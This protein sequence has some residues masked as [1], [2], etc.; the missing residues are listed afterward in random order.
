MRQS[1]LLLV[2]MII[3]GLTSLRGPAHVVAADENRE[4]E[5]VSK[6][7]PEN[8]DAWRNLK[9]GMFIHWGPVS[10]K[11]TEIGW[12]RGGE[13]RGLGFKGLSGTHQVPVEVYDNLYKQFN[14]T[15]FDAD[16]WVQ[17]AK[18]AGMKYI[19]FTT[20][21]HDGFCNFDTKLTDYKIT[22]PESPYGRDIVRQLADACHHGDLIWGVYYSQPDWHHPDY[23][24]GKERHKRYIEYLHGQMR[25]LLTQYGKTNMIFFDGL[26]GKSE[27]WDAPR[28]INMCRELQ[29]GIMINNRAGVKADFDT[30][31]QRIGKMQTDRP[32][33]TCM[34]ICRQ[35]AWKPNDT[36]KSFQQ[37]IQ[38]LVRVVGGDGN[39]L[40]NVGPMPDGR[41]E[42]R[43]VERLK[44]MGAWLAKYGQSIYDTRGG[45]FAAGMWGASTYRD[46]VIYLHILNGGKTPITLP[47]IEKKILA[48]D[49]LTGGRAAVAQTGESITVTLS[50]DAQNEVD[51]IVVLKLDGP[52]AEAN[53]GTLPSETVSAWK[54]ATASNVFRRRVDSYG[55]QMA[56]DDDPATRWATD[57]DTKKAWLEVDLGKPTTIDRAMI[58]EDKSSRVRRFELTVQ[59]DDEPWKTLVQGRR[60]GDKLDLEFAPV[61]AR[62]VRFNILEATDGPT[63]SEFRLF[64]SKK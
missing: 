34:T 63:I 64:A 36:M 25:E 38:T 33:E 55:P 16:Q 10:L 13:R 1:T 8:V 9:F 12:S 28:L 35:W 52:A 57:S 24:N 44:E 4:T 54:K 42:P 5:A 17:I 14:P 2:V 45:P 22:S 3:L 39:L 46:N 40:F 31:E 32:W 56:V 20:K 53:P 58:I 43:Q 11:G 37:C 26:G 48:S 6:A 15:K 60:I 59:N 49:V 51:A 50:K 62:R 21:H 30:P 19:V 7:S 18:D 27:D 41:I 61:V 29:P 23:R 47:P